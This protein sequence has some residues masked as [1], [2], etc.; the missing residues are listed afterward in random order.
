MP[1]EAQIEWRGRELWRPPL[2]DM[3]GV[4]FRA[5]SC[6]I[7]AHIQ[8]RSFRNGVKRCVKMSVCQSIHQRAPMLISILADHHEEQKSTCWSFFTNFEKFLQF[9]K[10]ISSGFNAAPPV[11]RRWYCNA[12]PI[13]VDNCE[14]ERACSVITKLNP[15]EAEPKP[16]DTSVS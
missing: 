15:E 4:R 5:H 8:A 12:P 16:S 10:W 13:Y 6:S 14:H 11:V 9:C 7:Y 3:V 1:F 2:V